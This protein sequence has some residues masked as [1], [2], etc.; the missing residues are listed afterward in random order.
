MKAFEAMAAGAPV[1]STSIGIEGLGLAPERDF[2][3]A[4][5]AAGFAAAIVRLLQRADLG[6]ALSERARSF[7]ECNASHSSA[8]RRFEEICWGAAA[9]HGAVA[10]AERDHAHDA[11]LMDEAVGDLPAP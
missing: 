9:A 7:V 8:A 5:D 6:R 10:C 11:A 4:D 2:L 1:V 3:C